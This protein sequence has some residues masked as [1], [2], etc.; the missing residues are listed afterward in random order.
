MI[1]YDFKKMW[2]KIIKTFGSVTLIDSESEIGKKIKAGQQRSIRQ[3]NKTF[4]ETR[5]TFAE[6][7]KALESIGKS[8]INNH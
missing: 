8:G 2:E 4:E 5:K 3:M 1:K 7:R 6:M